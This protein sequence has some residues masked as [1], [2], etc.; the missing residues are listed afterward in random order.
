MPALRCSRFEAT[1]TTCL[2]SVLSEVND[3]GDMAEYRSS[4]IVATSG[5]EQ[6]ILDFAGAGK[7]VDPQN[8]TVIRTGHKDGEGEWKWVYGHDVSLAGPLTNARSHFT[9][10]DCT[11]DKVQRS[12]HGYQLRIEQKIGIAV[13][14]D[15]DITCDDAGMPKKIPIRFGPYQHIRSR[16][17]SEHLHRENY[18]CF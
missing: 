13:F 9:Q 8:A 12:L 17:S 5:N 18:S 16:G 3:D 15:F 7:E 1:P 2:H 4:V 14:R 6:N 10:K 11:F